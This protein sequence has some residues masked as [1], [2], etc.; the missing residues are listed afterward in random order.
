[1][2][3]LSGG[4]PGIGRS[5]VRQNHSIPKRLHRKKKP[6]VRL[7][8]EVENDDKSKLWTYLIPLTVSLFEVD[9]HIKSSLCLCW[10]RKI[11]A[12]CCLREIPSI[13]SP[14]YAALSNV[15]DS[16]LAIRFDSDSYPIRI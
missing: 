12:S 14:T 5:R 9:C 2:I 15:V 10:L 13:T 1:M 11:M 3:S 16:I 8:T 6:S 4:V 7:W